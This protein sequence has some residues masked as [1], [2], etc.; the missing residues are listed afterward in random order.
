MTDEGFIR[1]QNFLERQTLELWM[2]LS[3]KDKETVKDFMHEMINGVLQEEDLNETR[4]VSMATLAIVSG[5]GI[6]TLGRIEMAKDQ[7]ENN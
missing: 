4:E 2:S 3:R 1:D 6:C 5:L 7:Q